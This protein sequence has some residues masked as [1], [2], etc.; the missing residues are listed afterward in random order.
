M[1]LDK[2]LKDAV[3]ELAKLQHTSMA[4]IFREGAE[5]M[6]AEHNYQTK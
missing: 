6:L 2:K 5:R 4:S 3:S 1:V